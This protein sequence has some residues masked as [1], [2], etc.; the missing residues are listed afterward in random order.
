MYKKS[1]S[2]S[3]G[4]AGV[5][6]LCG[7]FN[8]AMTSWITYDMGQ[9]ARLIADRSIYEALPHWKIIWLGVLGTFTFTIGMM[10]SLCGISAWIQGFLNKFRRNHYKF[11]KAV[12]SD[13][14]QQLSDRQIKRIIQILP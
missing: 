3:F 14:R 6:F 1:D 8:F 13:P 2:M 5:A 12:K 7:I 9:A 4:I 10:L 11:N